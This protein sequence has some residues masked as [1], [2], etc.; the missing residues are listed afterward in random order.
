ML[1]LLVILI[2]IGETA[3]S[4]EAGFDVYS[5]PDALDPEAPQD[6][7]VFLNSRLINN[8]DFVG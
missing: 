2:A 5:I 4:G 7:S 1:R 3:N 6:G 8:V